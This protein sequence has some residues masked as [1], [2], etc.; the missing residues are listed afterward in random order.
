MTVL[1]LGIP[2]PNNLKVESVTS[3]TANVSW[4][5]SEEMDPIT[6]NF[7]ITIRSAPNW[8]EPKMISTD[9]CSI[10]ITGLKPY[11]ECNIRISTNVENFGTSTEADIN[12]LTGKRLMQK[13]THT[14][15]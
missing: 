5:L 2:A 12:V 8:H 9:S 11:T 4:S 6:H 14:V 1:F 15:W 3:T 13:I 10:I 7:L